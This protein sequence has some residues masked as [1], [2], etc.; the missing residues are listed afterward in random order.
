MKREPHPLVNYV[1]RH[2]KVNDNTV[3]TVLNIHRAVNYLT[4]KVA[5]INASECIGKDILTTEEANAFKL[6]HNGSGNEF[7]KKHN[8]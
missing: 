1:G 7:N 6:K 5:P 4:G 2:V 3:V 8:R